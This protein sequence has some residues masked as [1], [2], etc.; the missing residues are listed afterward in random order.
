MLYILLLDALTTD[1]GPI[2]DTQHQGALKHERHAARSHLL[3]SQ[4]SV[5]GCFERPLIRPVCSHDVVERGAAGLEA[6]LPAGFGIVI[7]GD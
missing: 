4:L 6:I 7:T 5:A 3:W 1:Q 2:C